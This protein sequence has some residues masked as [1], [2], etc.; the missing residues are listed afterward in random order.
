MFVTVAPSR[1]PLQGGRAFAVSTGRSTGPVLTHP[2]TSSDLQL[3]EALRQQGVASDPGL[4]S[5]VTARLFRGMCDLDA[6]RHVDR[7]DRDGT[8][9][10]LRIRATAGPDDVYV[11]RAQLGRGGHESKDEGGSDARSSSSQPRCWAAVTRARD[12]IP[13]SGYYVA[14]RVLSGAVSALPPTSHHS[15]QRQGNMTSAEPTTENEEL[16]G[17][18]LGLINAYRMG[19]ALDAQDL[20]PRKTA[21]AA[22]PPKRAV[23]P[24]ERYISDGA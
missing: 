2:T 11:S 19:A 24:A 16:S 1:P 5:R 18:V 10:A 20:Y 6:G 4:T 12:C 3:L 23:V 21:A 13:F 14:E 17:S 9:H 8:A 7:S 15:R 22:P